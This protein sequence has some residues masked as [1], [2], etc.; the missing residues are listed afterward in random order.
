MENMMLLIYQDFIT[1][2]LTVRFTIPVFSVIFKNSAAITNTL[3]G[4]MTK[5]R[6]TVN[7]PGFR[8]PQNSFWTL[9]T[10][11]ITSKKQLFNCWSFNRTVTLVINWS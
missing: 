4:T 10:R 6:S 2:N 8:G 9:I 11:V 3:P 7:V 1:E 5:W